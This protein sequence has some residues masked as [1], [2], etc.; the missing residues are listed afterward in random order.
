MVSVRKN[1]HSGQVMVDWVS[2]AMGLDVIILY[3][4]IF[5]SLRGL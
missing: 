3:L 2:T 4:G 5:Y 1:P